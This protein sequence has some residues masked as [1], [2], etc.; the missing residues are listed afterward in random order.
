MS[1][2]WSHAE[3]EFNSALEWQQAPT[4]EASRM[5]LV[6]QETGT[7]L[8]LSMDTFAIPAEKFEEVARQVVKIRQDAHRK[9]V[10]NVLKDGEPVQLVFGDER[11][12]PHASGLAWEMSYAGSEAGKKV[13]MF[14]GY[15]TARKIV[16]L[17]VDT[18]LPLAAG[19]IDVFQ[20][21]LKGF[22]V[23]LP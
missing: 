17:F 22:H 15:V 6:N 16:H 1:K 3:F 20:D 7:T 8:T 10:E 21:V 5:V 12:A 18:R 13:F 14:L 19:E 4:Q 2:Q 11:I 9:S 23:T